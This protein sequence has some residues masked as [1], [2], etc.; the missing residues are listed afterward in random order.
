MYG[1]HTI[2]LRMYTQRKEEFSFRNGREG[3]GVRDPVDNT[4]NLQYESSSTTEYYSTHTMEC[5]YQ[6]P[7]LDQQRN[8]LLPT[9]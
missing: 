6:V 2:L 3:R 7:K 1:V 4:L 9:A 5:Q 8:R